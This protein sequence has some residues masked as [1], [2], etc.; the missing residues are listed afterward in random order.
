MALSDDS[1]EPMALLAVYQ[2]LHNA[3]L[4]AALRG[5]D[6]VNRSY[7]VSQREALATEYLSCREP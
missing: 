2:Q 3:T 5:M 6:E 4:L 7:T 1:R